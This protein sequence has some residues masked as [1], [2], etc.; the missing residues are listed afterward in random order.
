MAISG[1]KIPRSYRLSSHPIGNERYI[2]GPQY[3]IPLEAFRLTSFKGN[4]ENPPQPRN[5]L[6]VEARIEN[7]RLPIRSQHMILC[8]NLM[9]EV[10][11]ENT[12]TIFA[13]PMIGDFA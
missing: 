10:N 6:S 3:G 7:N 2:Y 1:S 5:L 11:I 4:T 8:S 13:A 12:S 9:S